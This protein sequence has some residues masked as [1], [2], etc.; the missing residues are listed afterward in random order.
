MIGSEL[1]LFI[2]NIDAIVE[3]M[4]RKFLDTPA[5]KS[6]SNVLLLCQKITPFL[7]ITT[8]ENENV[9]KQKMLEF[10]LNVKEMYK[11]GKLTILTKNPLKEGD[12][13]TFYLHCLRFYI[14]KIVKITYKKHNL[15]VGIFTMQGFE[16]RNK[17]SKNAMRR[18]SNNRGNIII[19][20]MKRLYDVFV[21]NQ[22]K[23]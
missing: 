12:N 8:I 7:V 2:Q 19:S 13:E 6:I 9:Y 15:G 16:R 3:F 17:E 22:N 18:F 5:V 4:R 1:L 21:H 10:E 14:P 11:E 23:I 20:N